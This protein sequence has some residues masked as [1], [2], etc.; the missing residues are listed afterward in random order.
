MLLKPVCGR[1]PWRCDVHLLSRKNLILLRR[2]VLTASGSGTVGIR[3][4]ICAKLEL[5]LGSSGA[6]T[7]CGE[8]TNSSFSVPRASPLGRS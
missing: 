1:Q 5:F 6:M 4:S 7:E 2:V 8:G 3:G